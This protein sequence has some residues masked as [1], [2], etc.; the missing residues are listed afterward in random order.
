MT[1]VGWKVPAIGGGAPRMFMSLGVGRLIEYGPYCPY[2]V[3]A[4]TR[5]HLLPGPC[6]PLGAD[7]HDMVSVYMRMHLVIP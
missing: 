7:K 5:Y 4:N 6:S 3:F 1:V 2:S